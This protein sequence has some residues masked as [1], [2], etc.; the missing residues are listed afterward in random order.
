M[1]KCAF[2]EEKNIMGRTAKIC[3]ALSIMECGGRNFHKCSFYKTNE[4]ID[5]ELARSADRLRKRGI[6]VQKEEDF[7]AF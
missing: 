5:K 3:N 4:Q 2:L 1:E 6:S 7:D